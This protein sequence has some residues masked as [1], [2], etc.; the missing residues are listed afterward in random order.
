M[1]KTPATTKAAAF[2]L[3][4]KSYLQDRSITPSVV[5][6]IDRLLNCGDS[7]EDAYQELIERAGTRH[8][9]DMSIERWQLALLTFVETAAWWHPAAVM[10]TR[11]AM[12][13]V[14]QL[15]AD[16]AEKARD[17]ADLI[18]EREELAAH[19]GVENPGNPLAYELLEPAAEISS[20]TTGYLYREWI[21]ES[22]SPLVERFDWKY[23]PTAADLLD[24]LAEMQD[25]EPVAPMHDAVE[26]SR[27][28]SWTA[29]ARILEAKLQ[30]LSHYPGITVH[31]SA[32]AYAALIDALLGLDGKIE[33]KN[34]DAFRSREKNRR[35]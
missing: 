15:N 2:L 28:E 29:F 25:V 8:P 21:E 18:R 11:K 3:A 34:I 13:R 27:E 6:V 1:K 9:R 22:I 5:T 10:K 24:A 19:H 7:L 30:D 16:I 33:P 32:S 4:E 23:W 31:L 35:Q 14:A 12:D 26:S 17:L 20:H